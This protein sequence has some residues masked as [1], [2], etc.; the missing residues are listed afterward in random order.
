[1]TVC[2]V[3]L[4]QSQTRPNSSLDLNVLRRYSAGHSRR[5]HAAA[6]YAAAATTEA[7]AAH[8]ATPAAASSMAAAT[9][10]AARSAAAT[11]AAKTMPSLPSHDRLAVLDGAPVG[12]YKSNPVETHS[13]KAPG[14]NP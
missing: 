14:F 9:M 1:V 6:A 13:L 3:V 11:E 12:L 7:A 2:A 4:L 8:T 10:A 5:L